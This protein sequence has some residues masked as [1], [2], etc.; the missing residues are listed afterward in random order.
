MERPRATIVTVVNFV[1]LMF[2][3]REARKKL[4]CLNKAGAAQREEAEYYHI[5]A[6]F[7]L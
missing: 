6:T 1:A 3:K 7:I 4:A 5:I 2:L